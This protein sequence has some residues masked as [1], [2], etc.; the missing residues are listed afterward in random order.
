MKMK[1][2]ASVAG[3]ALCLLV[4]PVLAGQLEDGAAAYGRGEYYTAISL[5]KPLADQGIAQA[6]FSLGL[7]YELGLVE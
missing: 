4:Q 1:L 3:L 7:M 6:Q 5:L 2:W